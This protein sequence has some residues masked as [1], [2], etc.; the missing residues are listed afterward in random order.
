MPFDGEIFRWNQATSFVS[1]DANGS[2]H[3]PKVQTR[4]ARP[5]PAED[6]ETHAPRTGAR[7]RAS[8]PRK[9]ARGG[10]CRRGTLDQNRMARHHSREW[11]NSAGIGRCSLRL[12]HGQTAQEIPIAT[13][14]SAAQ[15]SRR[16]AREHL[17]LS[18]PSPR[19][20][21]RRAS[22]SEA[23]L[24]PWPTRRLP[25]VPT[26]AEQRSNS[27]PPGGGPHEA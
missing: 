2:S 19:G 25:G 13:R 6:L 4:K 5:W 24:P 23:A 1:S 11:S 8:S 3:T 27:L 15:A 7:A 18:F 12:A 20:N 26:E 21:E 22:A 17:S 9:E 10:A 16:A 14:L